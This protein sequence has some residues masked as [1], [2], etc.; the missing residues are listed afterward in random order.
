M[1]SQIN[2]LP[3]QLQAAWDLGSSFPLPDLPAV[4]QVVVAGMGGSAI[5]AD[6]LAAYAAPVSPVPVIVHRDYR[7]PAWVRGPQT[8]V[9]CSSHSGN[10]EETLF[11]FQQALERKCSLLA[12]T[13]GGKLAAFA[14]AQGV[15]VWQFEHQG[16]PRAAVGYSFGLLLAAL[17]RLNLLSDP[18]APLEDALHA[19]R[20]L[21]TNLIPQVPV[22]L[23]AAKRLAGQLVG[24]SVVIFGA[25]YLE[26]VARRWKG[27]MNEIAKAWAQFEL[28]PEADHNTLAGLNNPENLLSQLI[29][30]FLEAPSNFPRNRLRL[31]LTRQF[32]MTSG[33]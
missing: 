3:D 15:T 28:L 11:A 27:Q 10:T 20:N 14:Q 12:I 26:P 17:Y 29:A 22:M 24:R 13:T 30:L 9:I 31:D 25:D 1:I 18:S 5:G 19:M 7:L 2:G 4:Q 16:Q 32:F 21:Q 6:L 23:N 8:L 33:H